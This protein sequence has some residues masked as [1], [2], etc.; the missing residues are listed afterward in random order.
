MCGVRIQSQLYYSCSSFGSVSHPVGLDICESCAN[1]GGP[2]GMHV[3][4]LEDVDNP[5]FG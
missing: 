4:V 5:I 1:K 3:K 2:V